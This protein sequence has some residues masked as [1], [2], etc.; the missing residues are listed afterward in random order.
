MVSLLGHPNALLTIG[1]TIM[2]NFLI[3]PTIFA[4]RHLHYKLYIVASV[5]IYSN[6]GVDFR[7]PLVH[8][9][10]SFW[11]FMAMVLSEK[12]N[13]VTNHLFPY[14]W[15]QKGKRKGTYVQAC[16]GLKRRIHLYMPWVYTHKRVSHLALNVC[17]GWWAVRCGFWTSGSIL[18]S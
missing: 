6:S 3:I 4:D 1:G 7:N 14:L 15:R 17:V 2:T 5:P 11:S 18:V 12:S 13:L 16:L 10:L 9:K 8:T